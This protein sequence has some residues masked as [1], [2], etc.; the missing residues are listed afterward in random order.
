MVLEKK[1]HEE[2]YRPGDWLDARQVAEVLS[3]NSRKIILVSNAAA[4]AKRHGIQPVRKVGHNN[5]YLYDDVRYVVVGLRPGRKPSLE[6]P[7]SAAE[8]MQRMRARRRVTAGLGAGSADRG[9]EGEKPG[10]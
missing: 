6:G 8:R 10:V 2:I 4:I 1:R 5:L 9:Q 3:E 7:L